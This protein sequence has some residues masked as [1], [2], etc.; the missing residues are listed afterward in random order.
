MKWNLERKE[1]I[2]LLLLIKV[3]LPKY[4]LMILFQFIKAVIDPSFV[5]Q[6]IMRSGSCFSKKF[7]PS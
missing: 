3:S 2:D 5:N 4:L 1:S 6:T 7:G